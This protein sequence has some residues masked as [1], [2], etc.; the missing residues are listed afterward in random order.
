MITVEMREKVEDALAK[1][2][3]R[4]RW[5][6]NLYGAKYRIELAF[7]EPCKEAI[8]EL[9]KLTDKYRLHEPDEYPDVG[10][11]VL[12]YCNGKKR[13]EDEDKN[14]YEYVMENCHCIGEYLPGCEDD[15]C[16]R[17][18]LEI[19]GVVENLEIIGWRELPERWE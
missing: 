15:E 5:A 17:W 6:A 8:S 7:L 2:N 1:A 12:V 18:E 10:T 14:V 19:T 4:I 11:S 9:L 13:I 16:G 3:E